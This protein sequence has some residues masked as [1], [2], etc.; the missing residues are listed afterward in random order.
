M[1]AASSTGLVRLEE[2]AGL[3]GFSETSGSSELRPGTSERSGIRSDQGC[4]YH[5]F[6]SISKLSLGSRIYHGSLPI[7]RPPPTS[8]ARS[9]IP[10]HTAAS[11][12]Q[13]I[14]PGHSSTTA[15][16]TV[17]R[18]RFCSHLL[19]SLDFSAHPS[20]SA[21][22]PS[23][24]GSLPQSPSSPNRP[25]SLP[26]QV[27][28]LIQQMNV[29]ENGHCARCWRKSSQQNSESLSFWDLHSI[30]HCAL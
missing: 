27:C 23:L 3:P 11:F 18:F 13:D 1:A 17:I 7:P 28:S 25:C 4:F 22:M 16:A 24:P 5:L 8:L 15:R 9:T 12:I 29:H 6:C 30:S 14:H 19:L 20:G 2:E 10:H 21:Q 26:E